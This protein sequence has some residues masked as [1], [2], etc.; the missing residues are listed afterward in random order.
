LKHDI[1]QSSI[2]NNL[3]DFLSW[4]DCLYELFS[5][6]SNIKGEAFFAN[7]VLMLNKFIG[8]DY[9]FIGVFNKED[10]RVEKVAFCNK[11]ENLANY[12]Y[13]FDNAPCAE[14]L[15]NSCVL[16]NDYVQLSYPNHTKFLELGIKA[17]FG[18]PLYNSKREVIGV[19]ASLYTTPKDTSKRIESLMYMFSSRIGSELEHVEK[20]REL[21]RRNLELL[22]FKEELIR[23]N[24]ELD[25][26]NNELKTIS[27][28]VEESNKLKTSFLANLSHEIR[29]PMNSIIGFTELLR[30]DNLSNEEKT[31]Y[32]NIVYHNGNQLM[33][34]MDALIDISKLQAQTISVDKDEISIEEM[35]VTLQQQFQEEVASASKSIEIQVF[36]DEIPEE[37][38]LVTYKEAIYKSLEHLI[39]NAVKFTN[40]GTIRIGYTKLEDSFEFF[41]EDTGIG[42]EK[43]KEKSIFELFRQGDLNPTR[44]FGGTGIGLAIVSKYAEMMNGQVWAE[45]GKEN[46]ALFRM[47]IPIVKTQP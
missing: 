20:E 41:V 1:I 32:L 33:R 22:V 24:K 21:K 9:T 45:S 38:K 42:I 26:I 10:R 34:V 47:S 31:E 12:S 44:E 16:I 18:V 30:S 7:S 5:P 4:E 29:T 15:N 13:N 46:G 19:L 35:L 37:E 2:A 39:E 8:A 6:E 17:Y 36:I 28:N 27:I 25:Q 23:K 43:G 3:T 11:F 40:K 14:V